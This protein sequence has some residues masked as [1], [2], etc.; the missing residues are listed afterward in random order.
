MLKLT[1][2]YKVEQHFKDFSLHAHDLHLF[3]IRFPHPTRKQSREIGAACREH[4]PVN[5]EHLAADVQTHVTEVGA[6]PHFVHLCQN[7]PGI[8]VRRQKDLF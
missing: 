5:R 6:V 4:Q 7:E 3:F 1:C 8:A 2:V